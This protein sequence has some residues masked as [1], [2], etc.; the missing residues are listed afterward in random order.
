MQR[1]KARIPSSMSKITRV[2]TISIL[3]GAFCALVHV[4]SVHAQI[5]S[6]GM[7]YA[8]VRVDKDSDSGK[9]VRLVAADEACGKHETR[10]QW[11]VV[12]PQGVPGAP[13]V[14]GSTGATG[15]TGA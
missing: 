3:C 12:G 9:L 2:R 15:A 13:G 11:N 4:T 10:V 1:W 6:D 7:F 14:K 8:C 5:P